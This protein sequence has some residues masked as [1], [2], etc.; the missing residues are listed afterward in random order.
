MSK[1][2]KC[3][4]CGA[5]MLGYIEMKPEIES[6]FVCPNAGNDNH[7]TYWRKREEGEG[8]QPKKLSA[9]R[10]AELLKLSPLEFINVIRA[11][12]HIAV[13]IN[14]HIRASDVENK[15]LRVNLEAIKAYRAQKS[16]EET[17]K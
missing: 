8:E 5:E 1:E 14:S 13:E 7:K 16:L 4:K 9:K 15:R 10:T 17:E 11:N 3:K 2:A 6:Q 12:P